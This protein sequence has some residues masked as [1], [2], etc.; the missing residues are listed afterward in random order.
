MLKFGVLGAGVG[1]L[2]ALIGDVATSVILFGTAGMTLAI[3]WKKVIAPLV[4]L[5]DLLGA[6]PERLDGIDERF[7]GVDERL[8]RGHAQFE[9]IRERVEAVEG[10]ASVAAEKATAVARELDVPSRQ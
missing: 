10:P 5:A 7:D 2:A 4:R 9:V 1:L 6:L 8:D 3:G